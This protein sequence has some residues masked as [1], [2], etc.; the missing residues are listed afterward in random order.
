MRLF[1]CTNCRNVLHFGNTMCVNCKLSVG[2]LQ[3][4]FEMTALAPADSKWRAIG[5]QGAIYRYCANADHDVCNWLVV[6]DGRSSLC[7]SCRF[8]RIIP[9]L[10]VE[11]NAQRWGKIEF[12][13]R[14]LFH[15][16]MRW[17][18]PRPD[19]IEDPVGGLA[20]DFVADALGADGVVARART[21]HSD[22]VITLN[23]AE[24]DDGERETRRSAMGE[25]YRTLIGHFRHE[26]GHFYWNKL[27]RDGGRVEEF[28]GA[29]GDERQD[30]DAALRRYYQA[31]PPA[32]WQAA[33]ISAYA[34]SHPWEDFAETWAHY[35][36]IVAA[37]DTSRSYGVRLKAD[38]ETPPRAVDLN[39]DP[40]E[41]ASA[42][43]LVQAWIPVTVAINAV[44]RSMGQPD[45]YP[46]VLSAPVIAKLE[47]IHSLIRSKVRPGDGACVGETSGGEALLPG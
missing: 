43:Q 24:A 22:G 36:H 45:L 41:A 6:A 35:F 5:H 7:E 47:I 26:I 9:D 1:E 21:G 23:I 42:E 12:A 16:L 34:T 18:L 14:H 33:F 44:N 28:R 17:R 8:N 29:F 15:S 46:F 37:L 27:M 20:F 13:K 39:F 31:G 30:Y 38:F 40:Y 3:D 2:Y 11:G 10:S 19:R 25:P 32:E 4:R